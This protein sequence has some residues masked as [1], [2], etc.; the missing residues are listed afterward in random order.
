MLLIKPSALCN[1]TS[2]SHWSLAALLDSPEVRA[3]GSWGERRSVPW[4]TYKWNIGPVTF[5]AVIQ[6][7]TLQC[8]CCNG[9]LLCAVGGMVVLPR[10]S[11]AAVLLDWLLLSQ[12]LVPVSEIN[13]ILATLLSTWYLRDRDTGDALQTLYT[14]NPVCVCLLSGEQC[15]CVWVQVCVSAHVMALWQSMCTVARM[16][17]VYK[18]GCPL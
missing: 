7:T 6:Y 11:L 12:R 5:F 15:V 1:G 16:H 3:T 17:P 9:L 8:A 13:D 2:V 14:I 18:C 4:R 10:E